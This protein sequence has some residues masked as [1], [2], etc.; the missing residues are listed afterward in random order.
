MNNRYSNCSLTTVRHRPPDEAPRPPGHLRKPGDPLARRPRL[1]DRPRHGAARRRLRAARRQPAGPLA[2]DLPARRLH[3]HPR[4][5]RDADHHRG[6][7]G[8]RRRPGQPAHGRR[9]VPALLRPLH[10]HRGPDHP[11]A[12]HRVPRAR[13]CTCCTAGSP[14]SASLPGAG[15]RRPATP[16][17]SRSSTPSPR[18]PSTRRYD[19]WA[20]ARD[21]AQDDPEVTDFLR[22]TNRTV[23]MQDVDALN[24][25]EQVPRHRARRLPGTEHQHRHRRAGRPPH[26]GPAG[27]QGEPGGAAAPTAAA[28]R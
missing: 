17:T 16:S 1:D 18:R 6:R 28:G 2:R 7:R 4:G 13:A 11:L 21:F 22:E 26:P 10:R 23:V 24:L 15:R 3:R 5:R 20:V 8:R 25:L 12:G 9:R 14:R 19:F 27:R